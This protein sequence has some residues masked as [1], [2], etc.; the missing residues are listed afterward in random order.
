MKE[1]TTRELNG[2]IVI[3]QNEMLEKVFVPLRAQLSLQGYQLMV[4]Q[5][6][7]SLT[8]AQIPV[9]PEL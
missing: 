6:I 8:H 2:N 5:Y 9:Q 1:G 3:T 7:Q 4:I